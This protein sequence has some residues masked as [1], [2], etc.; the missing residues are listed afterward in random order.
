MESE[1]NLLQPE[2]RLKQKAGAHQKNRGDGKFSGNQTVPHNQP[3]FSNPCSANRSSP[4]L[5]ERAIEI[6]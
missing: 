1:W 5:P 4:G 6:G 2:Q 3:F